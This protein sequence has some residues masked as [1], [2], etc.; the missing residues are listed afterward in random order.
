MYRAVHE[1]DIGPRIVITVLHGC[2]AVGGA[3]GGSTRKWTHQG[4]G[5]LTI[6]GK[7]NQ[8][9]EMH[10]SL[11]LTPRTLL[12]LGGAARNHHVFRP[13]IQVPRKQPPTLAGDRKLSAGLA[14]TSDCPTVRCSEMLRWARECVALHIQQ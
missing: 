3:L 4:L 11:S 14:H 6:L 7:T 8:D 13:F 5:A 2:R 9:G 12:T 10:G 1:F